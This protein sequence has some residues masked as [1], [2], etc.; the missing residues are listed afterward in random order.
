MQKCGAGTLKH[1]RTFW[2]PFA[3]SA[4]HPGV[5]L[6]RVPDWNSLQHET[7]HF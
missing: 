5:Y 6:F 4:A 7:S 1:R 2:R 3:T